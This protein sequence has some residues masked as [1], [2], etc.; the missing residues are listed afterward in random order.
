MVNIK[1]S[2]EYFYLT[3]KKS[4]NKYFFK[5]Y[6]I[7]LNIMLESKQIKYNK[8]YK[9]FSYFSFHIGKNVVLNI[10]YQV[11]TTD[12][13]STQ[14]CV[15]SGCEGVEKLKNLKVSKVS[16]QEQISIFN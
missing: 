4:C 2:C 7:V 16:K 12:I 5:L 1:Y 14:G 15:S 8:L 11:F 3:E 13:Y 9:C 10:D 6:I